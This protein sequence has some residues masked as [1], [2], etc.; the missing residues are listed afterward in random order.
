MNA[1]WQKSVLYFSSVRNVA[2]IFGLLL[3][4][5][6]FYLSVLIPPFQSPDEF[7]HVKRAYLL[8]KGYI[9]LEK[10]G[11]DISRIKLPQGFSLNE[12]QLQQMIGGKIDTGLL[13]YMEYYET[14]SLNPAARFDDK[15]FEKTQKVQWTG[16]ELFSAAPGNGYYFPLIY[17]PQGAGLML[18]RSLGLSVDASYRMARFFALSTSI[19]IIVFSIRIYRPPYLV[20]GLLVIPMT[21]FQLASASLDGIATALAMLCISIFMKMTVEKQSVRPEWLY[22]LAFST[23]LVASSRTHLVT[24]ILLLVASFIFTKDKKSLLAG[25]ITFMLVAVWMFIAVKTTTHGQ[26]LTGES[27][28][29]LILHYISHPL[30]FFKILYSTLTNTDLLNF[31]LRSFIG[32]LGWLDTHFSKQTYIG[33][34]GLLLVCVFFS[35][36][37]QKSRDEWLASGLLIA[38]S[39]VSVLL[40]FFALL[41]T[42]TRPEALVVEGIQG[43]YFLTPAMLLAY[44]LGNG[45]QTTSRLFHFSGMLLV[46]MLLVYSL[47]SSSILIMSRYY[48]SVLP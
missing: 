24:M 13:E 23:F 14:L 40:I 44:A 42:W 17:A 3:F 31:Y 21:I 28:S 45:R 41:V 19:L 7:N 22:L 11:Q 27:T 6:V 32:I 35:L 37:W 18:G 25:L 15:E 5:S 20:A 1:G 16:K 38:T 10:P 46:I 34:T 12:N 4:A 36:S 8:F 2:F 48:I 9:L 43:R 39:L 47:Y 33:I 29:A 26:I 30:L